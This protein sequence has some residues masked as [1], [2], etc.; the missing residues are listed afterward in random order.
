MFWIFN[1]FKEMTIY[2]NSKDVC[3]LPDAQRHGSASGND[4]GILNLVTEN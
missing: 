4:A 3:Y 2:G 1:V